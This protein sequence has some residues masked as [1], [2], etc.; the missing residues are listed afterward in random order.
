MSKKNIGGILG[1]AGFAPFI[2][3]IIYAGIK[4][5]LDTVSGVL[6][7]VGFMVCMTGFLLLRLSDSAE[8]ERQKKNFALPWNSIKDY[9]AELQQSR[10]KFA[11]STE[12]NKNKAKGWAV[13]Q[14]KKLYQFD[15]IGEGKMVYAVL[16]EANSKLFKRAK[17]GTEEDEIMPGVAVFSLDEYYEENPCELLDIAEELEANKPNN[18]LRNGLKYMFNEIVPESLTGGRVVY[19]STL[20]FYRKYLPAGCLTGWLFPAF[21]CPEKY[22]SLIMVDSKYWS[23]NLVAAFLHGNI[24]IKEEE[25][26]AFPELTPDNSAADKNEYQ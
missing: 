13:G 14:I 1:I 23:D 11:S 2:A 21:A 26:D 3:G 12:E 9:K 25:E 17:N 18:S 19:M 22:D 20:A 4:G 10:E 16:V 5:T 6:L 24:E 7:F 15:V 8:R